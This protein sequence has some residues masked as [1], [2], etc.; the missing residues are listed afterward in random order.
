M[1][2]CERERERE[3]QRG[4]VCYFIHVATVS[5][6]TELDWLPTFIKMG[7]DGKTTVPSSWLSCMEQTGAM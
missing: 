4:V 5:Q 1:C 6:L 3:R 2:A 7:V